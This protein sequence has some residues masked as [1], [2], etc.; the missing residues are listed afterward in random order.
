MFTA[1]AR[2]IPGW[3]RLTRLGQTARLWL[4]LALLLPAATTWAQ[5]VRG[6]DGNRTVTTGTIIVNEY[7]KVTADAAAGATLLRVS[8][9]TLNANSRFPG[10]LTQGDLILLIQM[11]GAS[12]ATNDAAFYGTVSAYNNA[13]RYELLEVAS[14]SG[15]DVI[16]LTCGLKYDYTA[17]GQTQVVRLPRFSTL[18]V[19]SGAAVSG[20]AWDRT[21]GLGGIVAMEVA[22]GTIVNGTITAT[23]LGFRGGAVDNNSEDANN[24]VMGFRSTASTFGAEKGESI[25]GAGVDYDALG[26]RY[27]RGAA[28]NG[29]GGGNSHNA[30]GGGGAN[31]GLGTWT[32]LGNPDRGTNNAYDDAW[33]LEG[34][35]FATSTSSGGGRGGY[36]YASANQNALVVGPG[37]SSWGGN[38]RQNNG[39]YGGRPLENRGR[40]YLGGGGGAGDGNNTVSTSGGNGGG[41]VYLLTGGAVS[42]SGSV[43]ANGTTGFRGNNIPT[44]GGTDAA[45]GG[46]GGGSIVLHV[47]GTITGITASA[48]GGTGGSQRDAGVESEGPGGGGGGGLIQYTNN[49]GT[50]FTT[51][52]LGGVSG[53]TSSTGLTEFPLNGATRGASG[54]VQPVLYNA[55]CAVADVTTSIVPLTNPTPAGQPGGFTVSFSNTGPSGAN[56]VIG[57]VKLPTGLSILSISNGGVYNPASG[58][59]DYPALTNLTNGQVFTSTIRFTTPPVPSIVA[60]SLIYTTTGQGANTQTDTGYDSFAVTPVADVTTT[61]TGPAVLGQGQPSGTYTVNFTNNGPSTATNVAQS[62]RLPAGSTNVSAPGA[63]SIVVN[64]GV[65][66]TYPATTLESGAT[67]SYQLSFT[68]PNTSGPVTLVSSTGTSTSQGPNTAADQ[69]TF[70]ATVTT[71]AAELQATISAESGTVLAGQEGV[72]NVVFRNNGPNTAPGTAAQV[73]LPAGLV[74]TDAAGGSYNQGTGLLTFPNLTSL[75]NGST[76]SPVIRFTAPATATTVSATASITSNA[77]DSNT[78]NNSA[79]APITVTPAADVVTT[80]SGPATA[81][82]GSSVTYTATVQNNGPSTANSVAPTVQLPRALLSVTVPAG[83]SYNVNTGIVTLP[84]IGTMNNGDKQDYTISFTLPNNNQPVSGQARNTATTTDAAA[85]NN[86]GSLAAANVTTIVTLPSGSCS[87]STFNS[88]P[89]TQGLYAE[90]YKGYFSDNFSFFNTNTP[91]LTRTVGNVS[92]SSRAGWGDITSAMNSGTASDP[93]NYSSRMRGYI[94]IVTGGTYT[95]TL[96]SDDASWLWIGNNARDTNLQASKAVV[97]AGG[98]HS[99]GFYTGVINLA[100]GTYPVTILYGEGSGDNV[101]TFNYNG[102]DTGGSAVAV[103]GSALCST[104]FSGPLPVELTQF[105]ATPS[106]LDAQLSWTTAQE[107]NSAYFAVE[108]S[109]AGQPFRAIGQVKAQGTTTQAQRYAFVDAG[110]ARLAT[111]VYYRLH[112]VDKDGSS[113]YS[114]VRTVLFGAGAA[115]FSVVPNPTTDKLR[116]QFTDATVQA[117]ATVYSVLGQALLTQAL[118]SSGQAELDVRALPAGSYVLRLLTSNGSTRNFHF[119]KQ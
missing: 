56:E 6:S 79:T 82:A 75:G 30:A 48:Q 5:R 80:I 23:G 33:N 15:T 77:F 83:A 54:L 66:V 44:S 99:A 22:N 90:Y 117:T 34:S 28:A 96:Y 45:G 101:L 3:S 72:F 37:A 114:P 55:Q 95:F 74:L 49:S 11:Q 39:G 1:S 109:V 17:A 115:D 59:V 7:A 111:T 10:A 118:N 20:A 31:V 35:G 71:T 104:Q 40:L 107:K 86:N 97:N 76:F 51:Q 68:A 50:N 64:N 12:I 25:A 27:G 78:S 19:N 42:G 24:I 91:A 98:N 14:V 47:S 67:S 13:G 46:G 53:T 43:L 29:G 87:G 52:V 106:N 38:D 110:A 18:T 2:L 36:S 100:A 26:G 65:I 103:P 84:T 9:N 32:G 116:V 69:F 57:Q 85:P 92:F 89:A 113:T 58:L 94:T 62:I 73:Q 108:R 119:V 105:T 60:Y 61:I 16:N 70:N 88:Q 21:T 8:N 81:A 93:D 41:L 102:P 4:A 112:Q 63:Q